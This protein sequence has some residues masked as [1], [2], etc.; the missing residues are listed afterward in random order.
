LVYI[1]LDRPNV[2]WGSQSAAPTFAKLA[3]ELVILLDIPPD[4]IRLQG[5]VLAARISE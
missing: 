2:Y 1:K 4:N 3:S 5:D